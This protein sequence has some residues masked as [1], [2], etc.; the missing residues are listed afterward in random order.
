[1]DKIQTLNPLATV[2]DSELISLAPVDVCNLQWAD[3]EHTGFTADITLASGDTFSALIKDG[4]LPHVQAV[5]DDAMAKKYGDIAEFV[6]PPPPTEE[7]VRA[8]MQVLERWQF[9]AM[10]DL[11]KGLREKIA[12]GLQG[13][14]EPRRTITLRKMQDMQFFTRTDSLLDEIT[15]LPE[16]GKTSADIDVMWLSAPK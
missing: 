15:S 6:P 16:V 4:D 8:R 2:D 7:E 13:L 1:M 5:W 14:P 12:I 3:S 11:Q 10:I 9:N